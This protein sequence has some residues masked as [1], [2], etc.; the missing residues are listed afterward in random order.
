MQN[1]AHD[2]IC[3]RV[4]TCPCTSTAVAAACEHAQQGVVVQ[5]ISSMKF[6]V[7]VDLPAAAGTPV[8]AT[9]MA[10]EP[11]LILEVSAEDSGSIC[12][13]YADAGVPC[14]VIG[15]TVDIPSITIS[16]GARPHASLT[17][18]EL[19]CTA[20]ARL[21][22]PRGR[23]FECL[24]CVLVE[25]K[26]ALCGTFHFWW[27]GPISHESLSQ[28]FLCTTLVDMTACGGAGGEIAVE[29]PVAEWRDVWEETSFA[30]ERL[31]AA[32][33]LSLAE[34]QGLKYRRATHASRPRL[35]SISYHTSAIVWMIAFS[36]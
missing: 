11:G 36:A 3:T 20:P 27:N 24:S 26:S 14:T 17:H 29:G 31:Q 5:C 35:R 9:L 23:L 6:N 7:Q 1:G 19:V 34:Q 10:E 15:A 4:K 28:H 2:H 21:T 18:S 25:E 33:E 12:A 16:V 30:L 22:M 13:A 32:P 8:A